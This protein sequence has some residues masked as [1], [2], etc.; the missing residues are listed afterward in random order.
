MHTL[1]AALVEN[2]TKQVHFELNFSSKLVS[3][4]GSKLDLISS[5]YYYHIT[6][7]N[8]NVRLMLQIAVSYL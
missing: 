5:L 7:V 1:L 8:Y 2:N 3:L 6:I 4:G